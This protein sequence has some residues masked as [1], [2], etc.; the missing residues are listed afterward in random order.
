[1][2]FYPSQLVRLTLNGTLGQG[3]VFSFGW[4]VQMPS[5]VSSQATFQTFI[6]AT[7][8]ACASGLLGLASFIDPAATYSTLKGYAWNADGSGA[9]ADWIASAPAVQVGS[10][11]AALPL[12]SCAVAT[13]TTAIPTRRTRGRMYLPCTGVALTNH[14]LTSTQVTTL[15]QTA[16]SILNAAKTVDALAI[17]VVFSPTYGVVTPVLSTS[18]DSRTDVQRRRADNQA[19]LFRNSQTL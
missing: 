6:N 5:T 2:P 8:T 10:G 13:L 11:V 1:M 4:Y 7:A 19:V 17:A 9:A 16:K 3:E 18:V 15:A 12:Q 14:E